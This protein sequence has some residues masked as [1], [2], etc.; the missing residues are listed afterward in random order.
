[1]EVARKGEDSGYGVPCLLIA[2]KN[3][4]NLYPMAVNDSEMVVIF[5][6]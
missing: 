2:A 6:C 4:L 1:M 3:D 5:T